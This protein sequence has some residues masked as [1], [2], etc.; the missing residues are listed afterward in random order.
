LLVIHS[1]WS[2]LKETV[3]VLMEDAPSHIDVEDVRRAM[4]EVDGVRDVR[5]LH[6][7]TITSGLESLSAHVFVDDASS[8]HRVLC[9]SREMLCERFGIEHVTIQVELREASASA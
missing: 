8:H 4:L 3:A 7:W 2:L 6:V 5:D 9:A 1:S